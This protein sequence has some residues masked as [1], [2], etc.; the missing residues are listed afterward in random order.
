MNIYFKLH[1]HQYL[2]VVFHLTLAREHALTLLRISL[3]RSWKQKQQ[4]N[5][6]NRE[7]V[8]FALFSLCWAN[9]M[10]T[11]FNLF[12]IFVAKRCFYS[13][14]SV[15]RRCWL[16]FL[17]VC[18]LI[19]DL[20]SSCFEYRKW[21]NKRVGPLTKLFKWFVRHKKKVKIADPNIYKQFNKWMMWSFSH[22]SMTGFA[23]TFSDWRP[24]LP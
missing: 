24:F 2:D 21:S 8:I 18:A 20:F 5:Q 11:D 19:D 17:F 12:T 23:Y 15:R 3:T 6:W 4:T 22:H 16:G 9:T 1:S 13:P 10:E 14:F 7:K